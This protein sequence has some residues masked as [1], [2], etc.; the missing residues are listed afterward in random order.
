M[1]LLSQK[2]LIALAVV[3]LLVS[4]TIVQAQRISDRNLLGAME[5]ELDRSIERLADQPEP[6]FY[7]SYEITDRYSASVA[8]IFGQT[9]GHSERAGTFFDVDLRVGT[10]DYDNTHFPTPNVRRLQTGSLVSRDSVR[11]TLWLMTD[12]AFK[13]ATEQLVKA[14]SERQVTIDS[15]E[16]A[17]DFA[18]SSKVTHNELIKPIQFP[19]EDWEKRVK[20]VSSVFADIP[21]IFTGSSSASVTKEVRYFTNT[22]GSQIQTDSN[23]YTVATQVSTRAKDGANLALSRLHHAH[24]PSDLPSERVL[25]Q[26]AEDLL[27]QIA[28]LSRAPRV[29]PY[30]GP[31]ILSGRASAVLFHEILGHRLE[32]HRLKQATDAQTFKDYVGQ[33]V[34]PHSFSVVF[35]PEPTK[36]GA[37]PLMGNY[38]FDNEG[39]RG[40]RVEVIRNGVLRSFLLGRSTLPQFRESNGHGRKTVGLHA[41]AR[42]SNLFVEV[43]KPKSP[44]ELT[45]QLIELLKERGLE[46]G[47]Y[48][49]DIVGGYT[50]TSRTLPNA[51]TVNPVVVYKIYQDGTLELVRGVDLIGTPLTVFNNIVAGANDPAVFNG[52]CGAESG[53]VLVSAISP[54]ILVS[55]VEVQRKAQSQSI[56]PILPPPSRT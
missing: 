6:P 28:N 33:S 35:D 55:Q 17:L 31:A 32:G 1:T 8:A 7:L 34:L 18:K 30:T 13:N 20:R 45:G 4:T 29:E 19:R 36:F 21:Q 43:D 16:G 25:T 37:T 22:E 39:V 12:L 14:R 24:K 47:L 9:T 51:F 15:A 41:V 42:Q 2:T 3:L 46:Y 44:M 5:T 49:D 48:F 26:E 54:S 38:T 56:L 10:P 50:I 52:Y 23:L 53:N 40:Q 11:N 27:T